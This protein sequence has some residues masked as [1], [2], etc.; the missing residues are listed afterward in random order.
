M[1]LLI[2]TVLLVISILSFLV[3][4]VGVGTALLV[5]TTVLTFVAKK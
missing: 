3:G 1:K 4:E 5:L 2:Q